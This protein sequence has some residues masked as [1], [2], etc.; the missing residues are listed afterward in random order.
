MI[1]IYGHH[2][3]SS[4]MTATCDHYTSTTITIGCSSYNGLGS[5]AWQHS[6][7]ETFDWGPSRWKRKRRRRRI[8]RRRRRNIRK[9]TRRRIRRRSHC[10]LEAT[11]RSKPLCARSHCALEGRDHS[12]KSQSLFQLTPGHF[13]LLHFT[14]WNVG[15]TLLCTYYGAS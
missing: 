10:A 9:T 11:V 14:T 8:R 3:R 15:F 12:S 1:T 7:L 2:I 6:L 4:P 13:T 5:F